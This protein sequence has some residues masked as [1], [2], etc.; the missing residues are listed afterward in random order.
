[1]RD[2]F[3]LCGTSHFHT[4]CGM[5]L[6]HVTNCRSHVFYK[7]RR[8]KSVGWFESFKIQHDGSVDYMILLLMVVLRVTHRKPCYKSFLYFVLASG[9]SILSRNYTVRLKVKDNRYTQESLSMLLDIP[10]KF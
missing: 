4:F 3:R 5:V 2:S 9:V 1:V 6:Y 8:R 7:W 10:F